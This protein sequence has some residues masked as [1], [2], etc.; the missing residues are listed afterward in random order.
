MNK[1]IS[2]SIVL[3][4]F[5]NLVDAFATHYWITNKL[6]EELNPVMDVLLKFSPSLFLFF[7]ISVGSACCWC[8]WK[9][10]KER[11]VKVIIAPVLGVYLFILF[12]HLRVLFQVT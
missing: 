3:L 1:L 12:C 11:M 9:R 10:Q 6:A 7:K 8:F 5:L 4:F 2:I